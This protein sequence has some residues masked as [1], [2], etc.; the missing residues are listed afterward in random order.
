[1]A[2][3]LEAVLARSPR[4]PVCAYGE[5]AGG[6]LALLAA[7]RLPRLRCVAGLGVPTDLERWR[8]DALRDGNAFSLSTYAQTAG[9]YFG[10]D[11]VED[12][13][14]PV[15]QAAQ[16]RA[17]VL[18]VGQADDEVLPI[19]GQL[20]GFDAAHPATDLYVTEPGDEPYLHGS[21]SARSRTG[22]E[23]RLRR[24]LWSVRRPRL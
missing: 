4:R 15:A 10:M 11:D 20:S 14:Q 6:H 18:L 21:F 3:E 22:F 12:E 9:A 8:E 23:A 2:A 1:M 13:W 5:S 19:A 7:A 24:L 16:I 17:R